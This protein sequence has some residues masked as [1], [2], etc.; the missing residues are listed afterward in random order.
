VSV[1]QN[2]GLAE[3]KWRR[4][5]ETENDIAKGSKNRDKKFV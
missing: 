3:V 5:E 1:L 4:E 2:P